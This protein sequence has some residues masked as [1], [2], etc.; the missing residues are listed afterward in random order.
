MDLSLT[1]PSSNQH[2]ELANPVFTASGTFG[3]GTDHS[4]ATEMTYLGAIVTKTTTL[5]PRF[6][7]PQPRIAETSSGMLNSIGLQ[8]PG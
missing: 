1:I 7:N 8:N 2:V 6:G 4:D 5:N 3:F